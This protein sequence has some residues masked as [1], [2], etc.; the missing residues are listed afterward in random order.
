MLLNTLLPAHC[1]NCGQTV[2]GPAGLCPHCFCAITWLDQ[3]ACDRCALPIEDPTQTARTCRAC[4]H[5]PP[6]FQRTRAVMVY[7]AASRDIL[8]RFKHADRTEAAP[9]LARWLH[10]CGQDLFGPETLLVPVPMHWR[11][12]FQRRYNQA[13]L[14]C[15]GLS[16]LTATPYAPDALKRIRHTLSQGSFDHR[17]LHGGPQARR[18]NVKGAFAAPKPA[19]I[20][21][22]TIILVDDVM[23]T[24]ATMSECARALL[25]QGATSVDLLVVARAVL[26]APMPG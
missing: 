8:L 4:H 5:Q 24:G 17:P 20:A 16:R 15:R 13:A 12:L 6:P 25:D 11:R 18:E 1:L 19:L 7:D 9:T 14:L 22:K 26:H 3:S 10:R 21:G 23:T 2:N